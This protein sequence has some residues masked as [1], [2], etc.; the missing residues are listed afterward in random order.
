MPAPRNRFKSRLAT[1][2]Y[3]I[4]CWLGLA[5]AYAAEVAGQCGYDWLL[6]DGEHAPNDIRSISDQLGAL[7]GLDVDPIVRLP[8]DEAWLIKQALDAGAQSLLIPMVET[9]EQAAAIVAATR[10]PPAGIRGIGAALARAS[11]FSGTSE[12]LETANDQIAV[13]VQIETRKG[14]DNI[15]AIAAVE[16]VD[17]L[18]IFGVAIDVMALAASLRATAALWRDQG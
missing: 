10:Y 4:G 18:F 7:S 8:T 17:A 15:E 1:H 14:V 3:Q 9:P 12:Y 11:A 2:E 6:I 16:G 5:D 13:V